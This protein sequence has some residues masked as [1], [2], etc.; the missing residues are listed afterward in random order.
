MEE[1]KK[2]TIN[3]S[4]RLSKKSDSTKIIVYRLC[5]R[6]SDQI[7]Y[8][9]NDSSESEIIN[10]LIDENAAL[11]IIGLIIRLD[12]KNKKEYAKELLNELI[13]W[14]VNYMSIGC[15]DSINTMPIASYF[16]YILTSKNLFF[17]PD[18]RMKK[19]EIKAFENK[20]IVAEKE[21]WKK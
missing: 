13:S 4:I 20:I 21:Y 8:L 1:L 7:E 18:F 17:K 3:P 9:K 5:E 15:S 6:W 12:R 11:N 14:D 2:E 19:K 10:L 16:L